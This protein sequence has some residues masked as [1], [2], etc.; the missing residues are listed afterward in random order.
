MEKYIDRHHAGKILAKELKEYTKQ[1]DVIILGLPRGGVPVAYEIALALS[2]PLDICIVRKLGVPWHDE[3]AMGAIATGGALVFNPGILKELNISQVDIDHV[4]LTEKKELERREM[5]YRGNRPKPNL[6]NKTIILVDDGI[7][8]GATIRAAITAL[9]MQNPHKIVI[10][11]PVAPAEIC[12]E[13]SLLVEQI[14]CPLKPRHFYAVGAWYEVFDQTTDS[15]VF[16]L[17]KT[18]IKK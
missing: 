17:L 3:L 5:A 11:V 12:E 9:R 15:E 18:N 6:Q 14:I 10:A 4:I 7:A 2:A 8:T 16:D 13:M 1:S